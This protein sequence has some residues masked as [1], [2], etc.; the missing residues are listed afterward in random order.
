[1]TADERRKG[2]QQ[3]FRSIS[4][5]LV[6]NVLYLPVWPPD[7]HCCFTVACLCHSR[8]LSH[9]SSGLICWAQLHKESIKSKQPKSVKQLR[10]IVVVG[11]NSGAASL[12][13]EVC[14]GIS[15][16]HCRATD[17]YSL[18]LK[19]RWGPEGEH[20]FMY[21]SLEITHLALRGPQEV[22]QYFEKVEMPEVEAD[23]GSAASCSVLLWCKGGENKHIEA[24]KIKF[25][26]SHRQKVLHNYLSKKER[27]ENA[28]RTKVYN[29][30]EGFMGRDGQ[31]CTVAV[32]LGTPFMV[33]KS[34]L[35]ISY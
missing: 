16:C 24:T 21:W 31:S 6:N 12:F 17:A 7:Y 30:V 34:G 33:L 29:G 35:L 18:L 23:A 20:F 25:V 3:Y 15:T 2:W 28:L 5:K 32:L 9:E 11:S 10:K 1:M 8:A 22:A 13:T 27:L 26:I 19:A 14:I 4:Q